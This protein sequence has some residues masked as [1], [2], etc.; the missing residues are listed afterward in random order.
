[1]SLNVTL[2]DGAV[3]TMPPGA[4]SL[5]VA[6]L[7]SP[8]LADATL[9]ARVDGMLR[10]ANLPLPGD[11]KLELITDRSG[12][13]ALEVYRHSSAHLCANA[14]KE[15]FPDAQ[16]GIGPVIEDGFYYDFHRAA[17]FTPEDLQLIEAKMIEIAGRATPVKRIELPWAEAQKKFAGENEPFKAEL[18]EE[19]GKLGPVSIYEQ[20]KFNDFCLGPHVPFTSRIKPGTFKLTSVAG[21][22]WKGDERNPQMQRIYGAV[23][24]K[25]KE[26]KEFLRMREEAL[27]RD[28]RKLGK[29][30]GLIM[31]HPWAPAMPFFTPK[32]AVIYNALTAYMRELYEKYD[33]REVITP[34]VFDMELFKKSG[35][36]D[37]YIENMFVM[38]V[39]EREFGLKPMNCPSHALLFANGQHSYRDLPL[40]LADF[41][42]LHRYERSGVTSGLTRVR[43]FAQDDSHIYCRPDQIESE[44]TALFKMVREVYDTLGFGELTVY[45]STRPEKY[46][47][48]LKFWNQAE[49]TLEACLKSA[50]LSFQI[51][52]GDGAFYG[53]KIDFNV[54]DAIGR[55]WQLATIQLDFVQAERFDLSYITENNEKARPVVIHRAILGS[56]E[57][58]VGVAIEHFAGAFPLWLAPEQV[59]VLTISEKAEDYARE[60]I[61]ELKAAGLRVSGDLSGEKIGAKIRDAQIAK[62]PVML[63]VG[64]KE[65]AARAAA[66][67][68]REGGDIGAR[69]L[70][71]IAAALAAASRTR[72]L[73]V[74]LAP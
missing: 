32:G 73:K 17:P 30:L 54:K 38:T 70:A 64:E 13:D 15:L 45:L 67:R 42:R 58:F 40:R 47:G 49:A 29:E 4:S 74:E 65:A 61:A 53:P 31:F 48:S 5:D 55:N 37:N 9:A 35:H 25:E 14:V 68:L 7:I 24:L 62:I 60:V 44:V 36:Y 22:Y 63:V 6:A 23:F 21:A 26:L 34:Q 71:A 18:A 3:K 10:D 66:V 56:L 43:S 12:P 16:I 57:R 1:M 50:G 27:K 11:C 41:C 28:H 33:Y 72:A 19:K 2:P 20:G 59:R 46:I 52:P 8:R 69:P 39:D 51:N